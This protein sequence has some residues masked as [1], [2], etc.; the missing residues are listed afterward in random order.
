MALTINTVTKIAQLAAGEPIILEYQ[1]ASSA[2]V[3]EAL[4][5]RSFMLAFYDANRTSLG[6]YEATNVGGNDPHALWAIDGRK[7]EE[8]YLA[9]G[10]RWDILERL[11]NGRE[12]VILN[13]VFIV[14]VSAP[15][16]PSLSTAPIA[17]TSTRITR[18]NDV[19]TTDAPKFEVTYSSYVA[20]TAPTFSVNPSITGGTTTGSTLTGTDGV[21]TGS[22]KSRQWFLNGSAISGAT[23]STFVTSSAGDYVFKVTATNATGDTIGSSNSF[24]VAAPAITLGTLALV[25]SLQVGVATTGT[26]SGAT[27][28]SAIVGDITGLTI[29]SAARTFT[30]SGNGTAGT[31]TNGLVETLAGATNSPNSSSVT[32][33]AAAVVKPANTAL[34]AIS[35][36]AQV[37]QTLSVSTGTWSN[38]PTGFTYQWLAA[39][40]SITGATASTYVLTSAELGK[41]IT[42]T[43][44][45]TNAGGSQS[46]TSAA[47]SA[48]VAA[49]TAPSNTALPAISG[50]VQQ[51]QTLTATTGSWT[52]S[53]SSYAYQWLRGATAISGATASTYLLVSADVGSPVSVT[54]TATNGVGSTSAT[55]AATSNVVIAAP[56]NSAVPAITG[57][58]QVGQTL[59]ATTGTWS[60]SPSYAY[61][62][63]RGATAISGTTASTYALVSADLG[64]TITVTVTASNAGGS[65]TATSAA[66][67]AVSGAPATAEIWFGWGD[68]IG[69]GISEQ[70][71]PADANPAAVY[72]VRARAPA[73]ISQTLPWDQAIANDGKNYFSP[74]QAFAKQRAADTGRNIY[75]VPHNWNGTSISLST[76]TWGVGNSLHEAFIARANAAIQTVLAAEPGAV[77]GGIIQVEGTNDQIAGE[78]NAPI[79]TFKSKIAAAISDMRAR[80]FKNGVSGTNIADTNY[81]IMGLMP[82]G[83]TAQSAGAYRGSYFEQFLQQ[84]AAAL[85]NGR[86]VRVGE[87]MAEPDNIH[88]TYTSNHTI[89]V[90]MA[91]L[92]TNTTAP[93]ISGVPSTYNTYDA[94][95]L[96]LL[97]SADKPVWWTTSNSTDFEVVPIM[98]GPIGIESTRWKWYLRWLN[99]TTKGVGTYTTTLSAE[100]GSGLITTQAVSVTVEP[101][102]GSVTGTGTPTLTNQGSVSYSLANVRTPYSTPARVVGRGLNLVRVI[103][104]GSLTSI[105]AVSVNGVNGVQVAAQ[106]SG[107]QS[108]VWAVPIATAGSYPVTITGAGTVSSLTVQIATVTNTKLTPASG[109]IL[110]NGYHGSPHVVAGVTCPAGGIVVGMGGVP[111]APTPIAGFTLSGAAG[112]DFTFV[113]SRTTTGDVGCSANAGYS[114]IGAIAFEAA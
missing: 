49:P 40:T 107:D 112:A 71:L 30:W 114:S 57:T 14:N 81:I 110:N 7:S 83:R 62:W 88:P 82:E 105:T 63:K 17:R 86:Y 77:I 20:A 35:G 58:A 33:A 68:S 12:S 47:T 75:F 25:P 111:S 79:A 94:Q 16:I 61:Q 100:D 52:G 99:D 59:T 60:G 87:G 55:S 92:L 11:N 9:S 97:L 48:V 22:L 54:V 37:G 113:G 65:A 78:T 5:G 27:V 64:A 44:V 50:T 106:T 3:P 1:P 31:T 72:N 80:I 104:S 90:Q 70:Q 21:F 67:S 89:G 91:G 29:N 28:G 32:V 24:T 93:V 23:G 45:A 13:G 2:G 6:N 101:A 108:Q 42:A 103:G 26:I 74:Y 53:P 18:R 41:A 66:T 19:E 76:S 34:P 85:T 8:L 84:T 56:V 4:D 51:G 39:G 69:V 15:N 10:I 95:K 98:D 38:S 109:L 36:T 96:G 43:V 46:A 102:Y 73:G